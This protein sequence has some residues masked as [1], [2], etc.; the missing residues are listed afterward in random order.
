MTNY[1]VCRSNKGSIVP[2]DMFL[3]E[4]SMVSEVYKRVKKKVDA[5]QAKYSYPINETVRVY[6]FDSVGQSKCMT[7]K[8]LRETF[9]I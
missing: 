9:E 1:I 4:A 6:E 7:S 8:G 3:V 5:R 2:G